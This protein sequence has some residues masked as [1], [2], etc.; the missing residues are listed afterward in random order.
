MTIFQAL[1]LGI[2]QGISEFLPISSSGHLVLVPVIFGWDIQSQFFDIIVHVATLLAVLIFFRKKISTI[3]VAL[4][5]YR[6]PSAERTLGIALLVA[7]IPAAIIG[8]F[9]GDLIEDSVRLPKYIA[10]SLIIGAIVLLIADWYGAKRVQVHKELS[11]VT[12]RNAF[13]TGLMQIIAFI[14]GMSRS[15]MTISGG[16]FQKFSKTAAAEFSFLMSIPVIA[17]AGAS[18]VRDLFSLPADEALSLS[19][20]AVGFV[21]AAV[22]GFLSI[23][24]TLAIVK[25]L[26]FLP[27][28][29]YRIVLGLVIL[30]L[31]I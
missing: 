15:G 9:F 27:F 31:F 26:S 20:V 11:Q 2:V 14:P 16:L 8:F 5:H 28:V 12:F 13:I 6:I 21:A 18:A 17:L 19:V 24:L 30:F 29:I 10:F 1:I 23:W 25:R 7:T 4:I 22:A 3:F